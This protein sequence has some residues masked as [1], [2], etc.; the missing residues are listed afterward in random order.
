MASDHNE[1]A[2]REPEP[3]RDRERQLYEILADYFEAVEAG[4]AP[5]GAGRSWR[6]RAHPEE[7]AASR[8]GPSTRRVQSTVDQRDGPRRPAMPP[9]ESCPNCHRLVADWHVEWYKTEGPSLYR[10]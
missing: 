10:G 5:D 2:A 8:S 6:R 9:N 7:R 1:V 3:D 4:R